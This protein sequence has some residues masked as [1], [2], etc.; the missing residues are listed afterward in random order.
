MGKASV[1]SA[2]CVRRKSGSV[3]GSENQHGVGILGV[4]CSSSELKLELR[5]DVRK[6]FYC[7]LTPCILWTQ[8]R[9]TIKDVVLLVGWSIISFSFR[10][11]TAWLASWPLSGIIH[12]CLHV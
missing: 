7:V 4:A 3:S 5:V 1:E 8:A 11:L 6:E 9:D 2:G 10:S 12:P